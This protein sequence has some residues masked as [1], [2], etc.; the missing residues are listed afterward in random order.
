MIANAGTG[1]VL[2]KQ[3]VEYRGRFCPSVNSRSCK[4]LKLSFSSMLGG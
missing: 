4:R 2:E 3:L 1:E